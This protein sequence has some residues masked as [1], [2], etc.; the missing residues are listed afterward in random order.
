MYHSNTLTSHVVVVVVVNAVRDDSMT[1]SQRKTLK[2]KIV[3]MW[4][5][6][7]K[8]I[9]AFLNRTRYLRAIAKWFQHWNGN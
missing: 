2:L 8:N 6:S 3:V 1:T 4:M 7:L 5:A 9:V